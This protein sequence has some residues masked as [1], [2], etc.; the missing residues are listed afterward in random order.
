MAKEFKRSGNK[1]FPKGVPSG[2]GK[3][4][5]EPRKSRTEKPDRPSFERYRDDSRPSDFGSPKKR[6]SY[7]DFR[8]KRDDDRPYKKR[9]ENDE[10]PSYES[11]EENKK[12]FE[13]RSFS[14]K[15]AFKRKWDND[16]D[17]KPKAFKRSFSD[18]PVFKKKWNDRDDKSEGSSNI[19]ATVIISINLFTTICNLLFLINHPASLAVYLLY[20]VYLALALLSSLIRS[21]SIVYIPIIML[22]ASVSTVPGSSLTDLRP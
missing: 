3:K 17:N 15:P 6:G 4:S 11:K 5:S 21:P 10:Q 1:D 14:D 20:L 16:G 22:L 19:A 18:K 9:E 7:G 13:K 2:K 12:S 8:K